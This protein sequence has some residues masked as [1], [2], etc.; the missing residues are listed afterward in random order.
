MSPETPATWQSTITIWEKSVMGLR[1][2]A[3]TKKGKNDI[4]LVVSR[5]VT[6]K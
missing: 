1:P 3:N 2:L 5:Q 6:A 4:L